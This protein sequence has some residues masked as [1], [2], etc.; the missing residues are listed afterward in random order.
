MV[1]IIIRRMVFQA[2]LTLICTLG[3]LL[4][5]SSVEHTAQMSYAKLVFNSATRVIYFASFVVTELVH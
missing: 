2:S 3:K 4:L 1:T 5:E